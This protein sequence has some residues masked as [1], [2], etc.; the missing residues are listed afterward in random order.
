MHVTLAHPHVHV[1]PAGDTPYVRAEEHVGEKQNLLVEGNGVDDLDRV[2][3]RAAVVALRLHLGGR[4][5]VGDDDSAGMFC[6][7]F[8][9]LFRI[10][11]RRERATRS[12]IR[13]QHR[14]LRR[15][16]RRRLRHEVDAAEHDDVGLG[17]RGFAAQSQ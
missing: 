7:P 14:L 12:E 4:V 11:G 1:L 2:T 6:L 3:R 10:D 15:E 16:N 8:A 17:L 5:Y 13:Q 9:E